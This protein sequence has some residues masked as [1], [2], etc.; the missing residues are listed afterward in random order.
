LQKEK[1]FAG[2]EIFIDCFKGF[3]RG[4]MLVLGQ[5]IKTAANVTITLPCDSLID[6]DGGA[7][8]FSNVKKT[9]AQLVSMAKENGLS[10]N[11]VPM[12][13]SRY[14]SAA[15][16]ELEK[17]LMAEDNFVCEE[18]AKDIAVCLCD[19]P[20]DEINFTARTIKNLV[21]TKGYR[22]RD[23]VIIARNAEKYSR[24]VERAMKCYDV[25]C[26]IDNRAAAKN[27]AVMVFALAAVESVRSYDTEAILRWLKTGLAGFDDKQIALLENYTYIWSISGKAWK[28]EWKASPYGIEKRQPKDA[29]EKLTVLEQMRQ[30]IYSTLSRFEASFSGGA[31]DMSKAL[32]RL[33]MDCNLPENLSAL[34]KEIYAENKAEAQ[35]L[36]QSYG[37]FMDVL[38]DIS[39]CF[40]SAGITREKYVSAFKAALS[41]YEIGTIP[42]GIDEVVFGSADHIR[43]GRP[44]VA[45]VLGVNQDVFPAAIK[46]E[47]LISVRDRQAMI[48]LQLPVGDRLIES[49]VDEKYMF[50]SAASCAGEKVYF[51]SSKADLSS[52][53]LEASPYVERLKRMFPKLSVY[54]ESA[55][56]SMDV[57]QVESIGSARN[58]FAAAFGK[59]STFSASLENYFALCGKD[60]SSFSEINADKSGLTLSPDVAR[61]LYGND[62]RLSATKVDRF[63]SCPFSYFCTFGLNAKRLNKAEINALQRGSM[64]HFVLE[65][66]LREFGKELAKVDDATLKNAISGY[67]NE[68]IKG[69]AAEDMNDYRWDTMVEQIKELTALLCEE[70]G[71]QLAESDFTPDGFEVDLKADG[72]I[73]P[74]E[75]EIGDGGRVVLGGQVDRVDT[76]AN[77]E[78][79]YI[80]VVDYKTG[81]KTFHLSDQLFGLNMQM[82]L[83]LYSA[84]RGKGGKYEGFIPAGILYIPSERSIDE[85]ANKTEPYS[86]ILLSEENVLTAL[87]NSHSGRYIPVKYNKDQS[88]RANS[89]EIVFSG[90]EFNLL[91]DNAERKLI[92]MGRQLH[93]GNVA[94]A[95]V[96]GTD[97]K[98]NA[99][100][101]CDFRAVCGREKNQKNSKVEGRKK[102]QVIAELRG[103]SDEL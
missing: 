33:A 21:R 18:D 83:Y 46:G 54:A 72:D 64:V 26:H 73:L 89:K 55:K 2:K 77:G 62:I 40:G 30:K 59:S 78:T 38:S 70:M 31:V 44:K 61:R 43:T 60:M 23:F 76:W 14:D 99:C 37:V 51:L 85:K 7:G 28:E 20:S 39:E 16:C 15:L 24:V 69:I 86:G 27:Q 29:A 90:D 66:A 34:Y 98:A 5:I 84:V 100:K 6:E 42:M 87:D 96:D 4:E 91:F 10:V 9:A 32:Y 25:P 50:Y 80:C 52:E 102:E 35:V 47:G 103:E 94:V 8:L 11:D 1:W 75:L 53:K 68:Y 22:Y 41:E 95:P 57:Q 74:V 36:R 93:G 81:S 19:Y 58:C 48:R 92:E 13:N 67:M 79:N 88:I 49:A 82:L 101:Y 3:T 12:E 71:K 17:H 63:F 45:F 56:N 65:N 97:D